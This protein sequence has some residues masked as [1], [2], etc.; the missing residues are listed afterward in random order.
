MEVHLI[1]VVQ[2][3]ELVQLYEAVNVVEREV[4]LGA[5]HTLLSNSL[6]GTVEGKSAIEHIIYHSRR[7]DVFEGLSMDEKEENVL[8]PAPDNKT[9]LIV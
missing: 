8:D 1:V 7:A 3:R 2:V 5:V 6:V 4:W 9:D